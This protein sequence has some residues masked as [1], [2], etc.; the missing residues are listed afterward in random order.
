MG[1]ASSA[2]LLLLGTEDIAGAGVR[3]LVV[4]IDLEFHS[5]T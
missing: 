1:P 3:R 5:Y 4:M 2:T